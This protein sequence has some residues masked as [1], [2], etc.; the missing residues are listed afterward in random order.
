[1]LHDTNSKRICFPL[2]N[3]VDR[4][5]SWR[6]WRVIETGLKQEWT[7]EHS[8]I[9]ESSGV[10]SQSVPPL[11]CASP[12]PQDLR[13]FKSG[14]L[15]TRSVGNKTCLAM[16]QPGVSPCLY[17]STVDGCFLFWIVA[18]L[19]AV[20]MLLKLAARKLN[21][22]AARKPGTTDANIFVSGC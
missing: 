16:I 5:Q 11:K 4:R 21:P 19:L 20:A 12:Y 3:P 7:D 6:R 2:L 9:L 10:V 14:A 22:G 17:H 18:L 1:M 15:S 8:L 13:W